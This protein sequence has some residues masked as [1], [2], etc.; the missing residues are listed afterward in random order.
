MEW[1]YKIGDVI[2]LGQ[3]NRIVI[4]GRREE[5]CSGGM[6]RSYL[7]Y[8]I[9]DSLYGIGVTTQPLVMPDIVLEELDKTAKELK[10]R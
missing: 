7:F 6:Q 10:G 2:L 1:K 3:N 4:T 5:E 9:M 8:Q